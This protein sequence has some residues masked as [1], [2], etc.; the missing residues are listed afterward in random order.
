[1][2]K[3]LK[4]TISIIMAFV[5]VVCT[6][7]LIQ[8]AEKEEKV[9]TN[10]DITDDFLDD[11]VIVVIFHEF[12][13]LD[14]EYSKEDFPGVDI[15]SIDYIT[16]LK[17]PNKDYPMLNLESY[18]QILELRLSN[19]GKENVI[20]AIRVLEENPIVMSAEPDTYVYAAGVENLRKSGDVNNDGNVNAKDALL[21]LQVSSKIFELGEAEKMYADANCD[22]EINAKDALYVLQVASGVLFQD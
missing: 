17:D 1:M 19:P 15:E 18:H 21:I 13:G 14:K 12:S 4:K 3:M 7:M 5:L 20:S 9:Y 10:I 8:A 16:S 22:E 11:R 2:N 6:S